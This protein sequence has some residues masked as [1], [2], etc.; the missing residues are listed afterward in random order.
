M[1]KFK[2]NEIFNNKPVT[3]KEANR[4]ADRKASHIPKDK[5]HQLSKLDNR[6]NKLLHYIK[7]KGKNPKLLRMLNTTKQSK[8][9]LQKKLNEIIYKRI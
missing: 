5:N 2:L 8:A 4:T 3:S 9:K 1:N 6:I 7:L